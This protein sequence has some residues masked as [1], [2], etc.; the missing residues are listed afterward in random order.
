MDTIMA[1]VTKKDIY[2]KYS[3]QFKD[4][5]I[6]SPVG[7][8]EPLLKEG[9]EKTGKTVATWSM[10][11]TNKP[12]TR[13]INGIEYTVMGT[14]CCHCEGCYATKGRYNMATCLDSL[15]VN[16]FLARYHMDFV[17]RAIM[18]QLEADKIDMLRNHAAGDFFSMEYAAMWHRIGE[19]FHAVDTWTYTKV[20][21]CEHYFDD[22]PNVHVVPSIIPNIGYNFGHCDYII[23]LYNYLRS[24][25]EDVYICRCG[26]D[27][28]IHCESCKGCCNHK[29]VL[30]VEHSTKYKA[31]KD[32]LF[33]VLRQIV[34]AQQDGLS[35][36]A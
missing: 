2:S 24:I 21:E 27:K 26:F 3:V 4:G 23:M 32:P 29:Y 17:E 16:T 14:C 36:A 15:F 34:E 20:K 13:F 6:L 12:F 1:R 30:F 25:G 11:P 19:A 33:P 7:W 10:L 22:L 35:K 28:T 5:K 9:N 31:E 8:I 18:A